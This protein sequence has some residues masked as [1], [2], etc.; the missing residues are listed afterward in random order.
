MFSYYGS[1]SK[2]VSLYPKPRYNLVIEPFAGCAWYSLLYSSNQVILN[3]K[4][5]KIFGI[6]H[7]LVNKATKQEI[8]NN[9]NF[10]VNQ[11][12]SKL[13]LS[14]EHKDLIG[15]CIN[16]GSTA[17]RNMVQKWSCQVKEKPDWASTPYYRLTKIAES[18]DKIKHFQIKF[19][20]YQDLD[21]VE[22]TWFIDP[23]YQIGGE[24]YV[25][26]RIDYKELS[27]W[28]LSRKGQVIVCENSEAKWLPFQPLVKINGQRKKTMEVIYTN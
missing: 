9:R 7:W 15:F 26:N 27:D 3:E 11:D 18:L 1:K 21:D 14:Q 12:I 16:R 10:I 24:H 22:A 23:P 4:Y 17:P 20:S 6:W 13:N 25:E 19:G 2:I 8:L 28:C 5:D